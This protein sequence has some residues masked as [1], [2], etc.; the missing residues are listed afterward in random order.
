MTG[1]TMTGFALGCLRF[2]VLAVIACGVNNHCASF[3]CAAHDDHDTITI[4]V[5]FVTLT[6][7]DVSKVYDIVDAAAIT[8]VFPSLSQ[9]SQL[10]EETESGSPLPATAWSNELVRHPVTLGAIPTGTASQMLQI[11]KS[12]Q[13]SNVFNAPSLKLHVGQEGT[14]SDVTSRVFL[15]GFAVNEDEPALPTPIETDV[16][17][18]TVM[19]IKA[20]RTDDAQFNLSGVWKRTE[21][22]GVATSIVRAGVARGREV[23]IPEITYQNVCFSRRLQPKE[24]LMIDTGIVHTEADVARA[25]PRGLGFFTSSS[26]GI[27]TRETSLFLLISVE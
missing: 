21:L 6:D 18:G 11:A 26:T 13:R 5:R 7:Q 22:K 20:N 8:T 23:Q 12:N 1:F 10:A 16:N 19:T 17:I 24:M 27:T 25:K 15:T 4:R 2:F 9:D 14:F 3:V